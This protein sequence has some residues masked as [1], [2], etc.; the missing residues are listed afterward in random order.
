MKNIIFEKNSFPTPP[1]GDVY[2]W[3]EAKTK[4]KIPNNSKY[5]IAI[6]A[7][8]KSG[9]QNITGDD[10]DLRVIINDYE[11]GKNK[12][13]EEKKSY[14]G[15]GTSASWD[16]ASLKGMEK[17]VYFFIDLDAE[18]EKIFWFN[19]NKE[20]IIKFI[21]DGYPVI[22]SLKV[23]EIQADYFEIPPEDLKVAGT[24][25]KGIPWRSLI[26]IANRPERIG[27]YANCKSAK[28]KNSTDGDDIKIIVNGHILQNQKAPTS[29]KYKNFY[30]AGDLDKGRTQSLIL[31]NCFGYYENAV[32]IWYDE[33]P[34]F[35]VIEVFLSNQ[36]QFRKK[37]IIEDTPAEFIVEDNSNA[38]NEEPWY[39]LGA[40]EQVSKNELFIVKSADKYNL[41]TDFVRAIIYI[42]STHG[43][44]DK[45]AAPFDV[46]KSILP[47]NVYASYWEDLGFS[48][49]DLKNPEINIEV[50]CLILKRIWDRVKD[51]TIEKVATV[52]QILGATMVTN[53]GAQVKKFYEQKPWREN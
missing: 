47:M 34:I 8:C 19:K 13:H 48:R 38:K 11:F 14:Q 27:I 15:F 23:F 32:E 18:I 25:Q 53:Y 43:Y 29:N 46:N 35:G 6:T 49:S 51:P 26:F 17:T 40:Y 31:Q 37:S 20:Q 3:K 5:V 24:N 30:F 42:E 36:I 7:S 2:E 50:G 16:G 39:E 1:G 52:Y 44:Y 41:D 12:I 10:D 28:Q 22:K 9:K 21:A 33:A 4:F 45:L